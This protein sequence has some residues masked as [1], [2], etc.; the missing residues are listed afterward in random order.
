[1]IEGVTDNYLLRKILS[2]YANS[3]NWDPSQAPS[4]NP[5]RANR[6]IKKDKTR[7]A[8]EAVDSKSTGKLISLVC[9][10]Y[11]ISLTS[12]AKRSHIPQSRMYEIVNGCSLTED[13]SISIRGTFDIID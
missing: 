6:V 4:F 10:A 13:E 8:R 9:D 5:T 3:Q 11:G 1:M 12:L 2:W 7:L